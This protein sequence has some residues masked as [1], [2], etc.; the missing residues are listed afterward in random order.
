MSKE[1]EEAYEYVLAD[2]KQAIGF[3]KKPLKKARRLLKTRLH[4]LKTIWS[5]PDEE[6][7]D[8]TDD[9]NIAKWVQESFSDSLKNGTNVVDEMNAR[10]SKFAKEEDTND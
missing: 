2:L 6:W 3:R 5:I 9:G 4:E 7:V 8:P 10:L 1:A